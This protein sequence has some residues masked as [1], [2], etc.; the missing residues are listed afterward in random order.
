MERGSFRRTLSRRRELVLF[1][2]ALVVGAAWVAGNLAG[3]LETEPWDADRP[4]TLR[5]APD[6]AVPAV[7]R[8]DF[9]AIWTHDGPNPF[10]AA[11]LESGGTAHLRPPPLPP[12]RP[13]MP[14]AP[15]VRPLDFLLGGAE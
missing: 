7:R 14:P 12:L 2:C 3:W 13:E 15:M 8:P 5:R 9:A 6:P 11:A 1:L 10:G 4:I